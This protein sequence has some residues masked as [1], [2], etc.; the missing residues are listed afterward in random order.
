LS[1]LK[2]PSEKKIFIVAAPSGAGKS[3]FVERI[4]RENV[5]L[6]D[7]ITCT[8]RAMRNGEAEGQPYHFMTV[9]NFEAH[10]RKGFFAEWAE[11]HGNRY[12]TPMDQIEEAWDQGKGV[13]MDIDV[14][15]A[16]TFKRK[17][18]WANTIFIL[19]PSLEELR[20]RILKRDGKI[21]HDLDLRLENAQK[22]L[23]Q[24]SRFDIQ[25]VNDVFE[26]SYQRFKKII[27]DLL[28]TK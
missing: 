2:S 20:R 3:S 6:R 1:S 15:G 4:A 17:F 18:P 13:I 27:E 11:V 19:P 24:A 28:V 8:T 7:I 9:D 25:V 23:E 14:Q 12:G 16:D 22:E 10:V 5:G 26:D 21:P